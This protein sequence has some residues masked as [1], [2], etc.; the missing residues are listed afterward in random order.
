MQSMTQT[1]LGPTNPETAAVNVE[2]CR[3]AGAVGRLMASYQSGMLALERVRSGGKQHV[4]VQHIHQPRISQMDRRAS[5]STR[6]I[7]Q[8]YQKFAL[9]GK[10][11]SRWV[12]RVKAKSARFSLRRPLNL[13]DKHRQEVT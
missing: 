9:Q 1:V 8:L 11:Q 13:F 12:Q 10:A 5:C 3:L 7:S 4:V 2:A 6:Q